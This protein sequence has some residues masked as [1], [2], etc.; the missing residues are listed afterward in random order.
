MSCKRKE[1]CLNVGKMQ[2]RKW[3]LRLK[4]A[5][6]RWEPEVQGREGERWGNEKWE[7][8]W[9]QRADLL[10]PPAASEIVNCHS[11]CRQTSNTDIISPYYLLPLKLLSMQPLLLSFFPILYSSST[12]CLLLCPSTCMNMNC[13]IYF[14]YLLPL[15]ALSLLSP[16]FYSVDEMIRLAVRSPLSLFD[17]SLPLHRR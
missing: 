14:L 2:R 4:M 8:V 11:G 1:I 17:G 6:N 5:G 13:L 15:A 7:I 16:G 10:G 12:R 3:W 9:S